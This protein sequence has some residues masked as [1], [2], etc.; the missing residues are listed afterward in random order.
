[1]ITEA[2]AHGVNANQVFH[3]RKQ[4]REGWFDEGR[5]SSAA[6]VSDGTV[7]LPL[8]GFH[9]TVTLICIYTPLE[10]ISRTI[11]RGGRWLAHPVVLRVIYE[12]SVRSKLSYFRDQKNS[13]LKLLVLVF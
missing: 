10:T 11:D 4:Y 12:A 9:R 7:S 6:L 1:M 8:D 2:R 5:E 13:C 3:W